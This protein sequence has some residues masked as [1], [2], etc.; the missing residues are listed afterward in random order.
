[1]KHIYKYV[2]QI[3]LARNYTLQNFLPVVSLI[4][5]HHEPDFSSLFC[6][7]RQYVETEYIYIY[8][9]MN[10][11]IGSQNRNSHPSTFPSGALLQAISPKITTFIISVVGTSCP[12]YIQDYSLCNC[13]C[14]NCSIYKDKTAPTYQYLI[15]NL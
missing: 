10:P 5:V 8:T 3:C 14:L 7:S 13:C 9:H 6:I 12:D 15:V 1:V 11:K 2:P 4:T